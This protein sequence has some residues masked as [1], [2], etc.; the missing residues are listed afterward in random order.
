MEEKDL[1]VLVDSWLNM[2]QKCAQVAKKANGILACIRNSA[3]SRT[4][5]MIIPLYV[6]LVRSYLEYCVQFWAPR[7]KKDIEDL[8]CIQRRAT[9][10]VRGLEH[11][12]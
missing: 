3:V 8:E 5:E 12:P 6:A 4:R 9:K 11:R 1:R 7:Y 10:L 2:T